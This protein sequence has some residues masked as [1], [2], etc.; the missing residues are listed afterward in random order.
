MLP[1]EKMQAPA[2]WTTGAQR[3]AMTLFEVHHAVRSY[4]A[5]P[6]DAVVQLSN[7]RAYHL[8][9]GITLVD[10][11]Q[12]AVDIVR[13][14][15]ERTA[16]RR[17]LDRLLP[18]VLKERGIGFVL[19]TEGQ[20]FGDRRLPHARE[21]LRAAGWPVASEQEFTCVGLLRE[22]GG[23]ATLSTLRET[24]PSGAAL[25]GT[26]C[27]LAMRRKLRIDLT[28]TSFDLCTVCTLSSKAAGLETV[29]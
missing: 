19:L 11:R 26:A 21:V 5:W 7:D 2:L 18:E 20:L 10:G 15:E 8:P 12:A 16:A 25:V 24:G 13:Q 6:P 4:R 29:A 3:D 27:V 17:A 28:A 1:S 23:A 22:L 9:L 14:G